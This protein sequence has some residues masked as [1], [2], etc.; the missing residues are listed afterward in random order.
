[1]AIR[2][3]KPTSA[4]RRFQTTSTFGDP[5]AFTAIATTADGVTA[6]V[7]VTLVA[8]G[9]TS[10]IVV[11]AIDAGAAQGAI[12]LNA[13]RAITHNTDPHLN[14][15]GGTHRNRDIHSAHSSRVKRR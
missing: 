11:G 3:R 6:V 5:V 7:T 1:M 8:D 4:G 13:G 2:S 15:V 12:S 14:G 9:T 10:D